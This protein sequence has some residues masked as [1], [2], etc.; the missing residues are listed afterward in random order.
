MWRALTEE[1]RMHGLSKSKI[2]DGL[3]C[4][5][6]LWLEVH[7]PE[8]VVY[9][10]STERIFAVGHEVGRIA[11]GLCPGGVLAGSRRDGRLTGA[12]HAKPRPIRSG[13]SQSPATAPS[14]R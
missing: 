8:L 10:P 12:D 14:S 1:T 6:L 2:I 4:P 11:R 3:Q 9:D 5:R 13:C 7:H